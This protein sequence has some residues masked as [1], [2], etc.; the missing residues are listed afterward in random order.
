MEEKKNE[1]REKRRKKIIELKAAMKTPIDPLPVT[2]VSEYE[3]LR[4]SNIKEREE[5]M[6][7]SEFFEDLNDYKR[8]IGLSK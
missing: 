1:A 2:E 5:A 8:N 3:K 7:A 6:L 4:M